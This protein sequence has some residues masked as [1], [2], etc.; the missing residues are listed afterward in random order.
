MMNTLGTLI[1]L[2]ALVVRQVTMAFGELME[3]S[4][5]HKIQLDFATIAR[6]SG[7]VGF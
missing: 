4:Y 5:S 2:S 3:N 1:T 6:D 7:R